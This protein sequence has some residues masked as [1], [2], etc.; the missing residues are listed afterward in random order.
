MDSGRLRIAEVT[1]RFPSIPAFVSFLS[2]QLGFRSLGEVDRKTSTHF[3]LFE[4][5]KAPWE[6]GSDL[7]EEQARRGLIAKGEELLKPCIYKRR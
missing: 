1:S 5:T 6:K 3:V 2:S 7:A 4:F